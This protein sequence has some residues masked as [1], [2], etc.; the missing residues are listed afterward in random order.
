MEVGTD[1]LLVVLAASLPLHAEPVNRLGLVH[2]LASTRPVEVNQL[3][4]AAVEV[5]LLTPLAELHRVLHLPHLLVELPLRPLDRRLVLN[6]LLLPIVLHIAPHLAIHHGLVELSHNP[7][8]EAVATAAD[9]GCRKI[10]GV[11]DHLTRCIRL[12]VIC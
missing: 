11:A 5:L 7:S 12:F 8:V 4:G 9:A 1:A 2:V 10:A 6:L 3:T